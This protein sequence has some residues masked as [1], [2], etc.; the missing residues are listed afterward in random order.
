M[1]EVITKIF[2]F[3]FGSCIG[4]FLNVCIFRMPQ[5][6]YSI[7]SP[8]SYCP[9]CKKSIFWYDNIPVLAF[10]FLGGRCRFCKAKISFQ[11]PLVEILAGLAFLAVYIGWGISLDALILDVFICG[12]IVSTFIDI[13]WRIIP[14]EISL[15]GIAVGLIFALLKSLPI[16][17]EFP[18]IP[19][20]DSFFGVIIGGFLVYASGQ[21]GNFLFFK[22]MK[23]ESIEGETESIGGGDVKLLAMIGSF[24]G[25]KLAILTFFIAPFL[26]AAVGVYVLLRKKSHL[27]PYGPFLSIAALLALIYGDTIIRLLLIR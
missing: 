5:E 20:V 12:L 7:I 23:K 2:I 11:Y 27:I 24:I 9:S 25:W 3:I 8:S 4:S 26:G 19:L 1:Q 18:R 10:L 17:K 15:G 6:K 22:L 21:L 14:D 16:I 13:K